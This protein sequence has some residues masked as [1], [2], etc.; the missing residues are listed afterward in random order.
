MTYLTPVDGISGQIARSVGDLIQNT[1]YVGPAIFFY[2][3]M[4]LNASMRFIQQNMHNIP[5][6]GNLTAKTKGKTPFQTTMQHSQSIMSLVAMGAIYAAI[7]DQEDPYI[8]IISRYS[9]DKTKQAEFLSKKGKFDS[10]KIGRGDDAIYVPFVNTAFAAPFSII[11]GIRDAKRSGKEMPLATSAMLGGALFQGLSFFEN[12]LMFQQLGNMYSFIKEF[13]RS[14]FSSEAAAAKLIKGVLA[15][16]KNLTVSP[17]IVRNIM[18]MSTDPVAANK[19]IQSAIFENIPYFH[20][21]AGLPAL[22]II[23]EVLGPD[24]GMYRLYTKTTPDLDFRWLAETGYKI[25]DYARMDDRKIFE[26]IDVSFED[27]HKAAQNAAPVMREF[28]KSLRKQI[29]YGK[30]TPER[31]KNLSRKIN[32]IWATSLADVLQKRGVKF[33]SEGTP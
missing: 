17:S 11:G 9:T 29:D 2:G 21:E 22:N 25:P 7:E 14:E 31:Q 8:D 6:V 4:F 12:A 23:G 5:I 18:R 3:S 10:I 26:D 32:N 24:T 20:S 28:L 16:A 30:A 15:P 13:S 33:F 19:H 1:Q 27:K